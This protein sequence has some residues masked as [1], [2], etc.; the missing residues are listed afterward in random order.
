VPPPTYPLQAELRLVGQGGCIKIRNTDLV[1]STNLA[2][3]LVGLL[4]S[5]DDRLTVCYRGL[6]LGEYDESLRRFFPHVRWLEAFAP[7]L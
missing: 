2:G 7:S 5:T 4:P 1:L 3:E 6:A